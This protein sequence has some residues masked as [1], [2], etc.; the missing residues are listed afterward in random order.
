MIGRPDRTESDGFST[1]AD[2]RKRLGQYFTGV[3]LARFLAAL[4]GA[5]KATASSTRWQGEGTCCLAP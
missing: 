1:N 2:R 5:E 4:A 3:R